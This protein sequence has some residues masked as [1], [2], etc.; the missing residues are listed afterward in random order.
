MDLEDEEQGEGPPML[1]GLESFLKGLSP[2]TIQ[3]QLGDEINQMLKK[4]R[5]LKAK[6]EEQ[7]Q[8]VP[9]F[10]KIIKHEIFLY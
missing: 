3:F 4:Y 9:H 8:E 2:Q 6:L 1:R 7:E 10:L 5:A